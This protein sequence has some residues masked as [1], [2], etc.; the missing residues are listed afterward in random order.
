MST[1]AMQLS[2]N[3]PRMLEVPAQ[4]P[5]QTVCATLEHSGIPVSEFENVTDIC[6]DFTDMSSLQVFSH[7][8]KFSINQMPGAVLD[9]FPV[10]GDSYGYKPSDNPEVLG[11]VPWTLFP[12][13]CSKWW[14]GTVSYKLMAIRPKE[15]SGKIL[16]KYA[17]DVRDEF[18]DDE[19]DRMICKEWDLSQGN[20]CEFDIN[21]VNT[22]KARPTWIPHLDSFTAKDDNNSPPGTDAVFTRQILPYQEWSFG[23]LQLLSAQRLQIGSLYP[24]DIRILVFRVFKNATFYMPTDFRGSMKHCLTTLS[25]PVPVV[26]PEPDN[27]G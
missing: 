1:Q 24:D 18:D 22:I 8:F 16:I 2:F 9:E 6:P 15:M 12:F 26:P 3:P 27:N 5:P 20:E 10:L 23:R 11:V 7:S 21:G 14:N 4:P 13:F 19:L 17:F 25:P